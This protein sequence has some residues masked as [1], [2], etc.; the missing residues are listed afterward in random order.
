[1]LEIPMTH[2]ERDMSKYV[3][4]IIFSLTLSLFKWVIGK[5]VVMKNL[6]GGAIDSCG[7]GSREPLSSFSK[8]E[9]SIF[10]L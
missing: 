5:R 2:R 6:G 7:S 4:D 10:H 1:M 3:P 8:K 9:G